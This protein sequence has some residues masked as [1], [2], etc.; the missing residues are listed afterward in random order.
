MH[1]CPV[2][3]CL[4]FGRFAKAIQRL[5]VERGETGEGEG[6]WIGRESVDWRFM[7]D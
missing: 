1:V 4:A 3:V 7:T 5:R 6:K 2:F